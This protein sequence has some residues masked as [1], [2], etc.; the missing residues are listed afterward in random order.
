VQHTHV[1][2]YVYIYV[3]IYP[4]TLCDAFNGI[5]MFHME[6]NMNPDQVTKEMDLYTSA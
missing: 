1:Y 6:C 2:A 5:I 3:Y 4:N